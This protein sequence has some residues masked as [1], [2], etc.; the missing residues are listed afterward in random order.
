VRPLSQD[1]LRAVLAALVIVLIVVPVGGGVWLGVVLGE[2]PCILCWSQRTSMVLMALA[3]LFVVR[4]GPRPRYIGTV[5]LLGAWG[6]FMSLRHA[7]LHLARDVGQGFAAPYFGV[8]TYVWAGFIHWVV[9]GAVG[10][11]FLL[12]REDAPSYGPREPGR[13]GRFAIWLFMLVVAG[14]ALQAFVTTGPPP[15]MGQADPVR[16]SLNPRHWVWLWGDELGGAISLRGPWAIPRPDPAA[17]EVDAG[18][19]GGPLANLPVLDVERRVT[20]TAPLDGQLT[21]LAYDSATSRFLAVTDHYGVYVLDGTLSRVE[22]HV[23]LDH[24]YSIDLTPLAGAAW[25]GDTLAVMSTN[26]SYV[27]LRPDP[28]ADPDREWR[29]FTRSDGGVTEL[30]RSRFA[31]VRARM[32][33]VLSLAYDRQADELITITVPSPRHRRLVVSRFARADRELSSEFEPRPASGLALSGP[34]RSL[35]DYLVTGAAVAD[36]K[37]YALSAAYST[38]LVIDLRTKL[39]NEAYAVPGIQRPVGLAARGPELLVAQADGG[40]AV[41]SRPQR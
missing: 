28:T 38:L 37:L 27:L 23:V 21:G 41:V 8:H 11:L 20:I 15:F 19:A 33:Y 5:V 7:S 10:A 31:T 9:L 32:M 24:Q 39:V 34:D 3:G 2:A 18:P 29:H 12:L 25:M 36:G 17:V 1:G 4:Y 14:N 35:A 22:H 30:L 40:I 26:K 13:A 16:F 6:V